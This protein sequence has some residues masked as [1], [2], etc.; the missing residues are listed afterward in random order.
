MSL[1]TSFLSTLRHV[2]LSQGFSSLQL[3]TQAISACMV[4]GAVDLPHAVQL[5]QQV[6][7]KQFKPDKK[8]YA[9]LMS[10]AGKAGQLDFAFQLLNDMHAE[11]LAPTSTICSGLV[12]ACL[13][14][15]SLPLARKVY[16]LCRQQRVFPGISQF[17][18]MMDWYAKDFR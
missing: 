15:G 16:D 12:H 10:L 17:N 18:R 6:S 9:C 7:L 3:Y 2:I 13:Q 5:Y 4:P 11:G 1:V 14:Q 8:L